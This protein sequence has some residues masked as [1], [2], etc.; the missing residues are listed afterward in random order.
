MVGQ[1]TQ[2]KEGHGEDSQLLSS[3]VGP[4][5]IWEEL[6]PA[7]PFLRY[8]GEAL[9]GLG[10]NFPPQNA[11]G[12]SK[13]LHD[14]RAPEDSAARSARRTRTPNGG[15]GAPFPENSDPTQQE[16][17]QG[18]V[19]G[20]RA[21]K[22]QGWQWLT[23]LCVPSEGPARH[24]AQGPPAAGEPHARPARKQTSWQPHCT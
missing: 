16:P 20:P 9:R 14:S 1:S 6:L 12:L 3:P 8:E 15:C 19:G 17:P 24:R 13:L 2:G 23:V 7:L 22:V 5:G 11:E 18:R 21:H 4:W 10:E